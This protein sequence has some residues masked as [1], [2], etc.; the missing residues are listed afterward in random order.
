MIAAHGEVMPLRERIAA[1]FD[2]ADSAPENV[3]GV[4]ILLVA[5]H[6]T[7]FAADAFFHIE[8]EAVLL[9]GC[10]LA[11]RNKLNGFRANAGGCGV[12]VIQQQ[13]AFKQR[14]I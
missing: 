13:I 4:S 3:G 11:G 2:L 5:G 9:P 12:P 14:E 8:V 7:T 1:A 10:G 6:Y